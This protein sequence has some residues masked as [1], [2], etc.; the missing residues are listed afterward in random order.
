MNER[1]DL[2]RV[3]MPRIAARMLVGLSKQII[4]FFMVL[5]LIFLLTGCAKPA[6]V[7]KI[8]RAEQKWNRRN[9][10]SYRIQVQAGGWWHLQNYTVVVRNEKV[11]SYFATCTL[12]PADSEPCDVYSFDPEDFTVPGLFATARAQ[13]AMSEEWTVITFDPNYS[14]PLTIRTDYP[15]IADEEQVWTLLEFSQ[16]SE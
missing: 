14:F 11:V 6:L 8:D 16:E 3:R 15:Q 5:V 7:Q 10:N 2:H 1:V 13:A 12:A 4:P 9:I